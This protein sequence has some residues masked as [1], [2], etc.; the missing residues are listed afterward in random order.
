MEHR[1]YSYIVDGVPTDNEVV[2]NV[3]VSSIEHNYV[4]GGSLFAGRTNER[5]IANFKYDFSSGLA[6]LT[7]EQPEQN[8]FTG[9]LVKLKG[10]EFTCDNS[11]G[12]TT[13]VFPD[14][15]KV[16]FPITQRLNPT[17]F[18]LDI[19]KSEFDH[20]Y[21]RGTGVAFVGIT[22]DIF[23]EASTG[24]LFEVVATP[25]PT[26]VAARIGVSSIQHNYVKGGSIFVGINTDIFPGDSEV[27]PFGDT[28]SIQ[29][30]TP[31]GELV[32]NVGTSSITHF[33]VSGG[34]V[35]YGETSGGQLQHITGPGVSEATVAAIDFERQI[36][37]YAVNNRPWGSFIVAETSRVTDFQYNNV[38]GFATVFAE[39]INAEN[40][41]T[42]SLK[43]Y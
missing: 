18:Q 27:S 5:D 23:P 38:T 15:D 6:I 32:I 9:D 41:D 20:T 34:E 1:G 26:Q 37:G 17:Q 22:T 40:G 12:I 24:K 10:L 3:G 25:S 33:Y 35:Q 29:S 4:R 11:V 13:T 31:D 8:L 19:G 14:T 16:L 39:G 42:R 43:W 28:Y 7:F 36:S 30:I 2:V 21:V